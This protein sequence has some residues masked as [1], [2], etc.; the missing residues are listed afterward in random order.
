MICFSPVPLVLT[1][2]KASSV[3]LWKTILLPSGDESPGRSSPSGVEV[4]RTTPPPSD[5]LI[6]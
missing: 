6:V 2:N 3:V 5:D 1:T 4:T